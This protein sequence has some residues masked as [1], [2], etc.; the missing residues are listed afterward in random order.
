M[1][2][3]YA[4]KI[5]KCFQD[6]KFIFDEKSHT[7]TYQGSKF[8]SVTG[9]IG[10]FSQKFDSD[11]WSKRKAKE[12]EITQDEILKE[13]KDKADVACLLGSQVHFMIES[14]L[15]G[16]DAPKPLEDE[17]LN[18]KSIERFNKWY[19]LYL[20]KLIK[21]TPIAQEL[22]V[23]SPKLKIA[24]TIDAL[25]Y[26]KDSLIVGD[27]KTNGDWSDDLS[28]GYQKLYDPFSDLW[29]NTLNKYSLQLSFYRL[30]LEEWNIPTK[31]AFLC[32]I[33]PDG[34]A[35]FFPAKDLRPG[36]KKYYNI[37]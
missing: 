1:T 4:E 20:T 9:E 33:G 27:W 22:R 28:K 29:D 32:W 36:L 15:N 24:G 17:A 34:E 13:W 5:I 8:T 35:K 25:F 16:V 14:F 11:Y 6:P 18:N 10:K 37:K 26:W 3:E 21:M 7:Y 19:Q 31:A 23:F 12:R 2:L 30:I